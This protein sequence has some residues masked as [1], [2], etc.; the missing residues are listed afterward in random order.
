MYPLSLTTH[1]DAVSVV[2]EPVEGA[3]EHAKGAIALVGPGTVRITFKES[4]T[5]SND[6]RRQ[7]QAQAVV[8]LYIKAPKCSPR[9]DQLQGKLESSQSVWAFARL[10]TGTLG[11]DKT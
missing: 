8:I 6:R 5:L 2:H 3:V 9:V 7:D 4:R 1:L 11:L 10:T